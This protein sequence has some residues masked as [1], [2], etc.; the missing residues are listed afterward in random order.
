MSAITDLYTLL[1]GKDHIKDGNVIDMAEHGRVGGLSTGQAFKFVGGYNVAKKITVD[2]DYTYI[3]TAVIGT[4]DS[5]ATWQ[6]YRIDTSVAGDTRFM[7]ADGDD[8]YD[9]VATDLTAL[10]YS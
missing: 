2:G 4:A 3:A 8:S 7:W 9:N 5:S 10:S 6:V 1:F